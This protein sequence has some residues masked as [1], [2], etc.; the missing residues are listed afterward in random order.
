M[1]SRHAGESGAPTTGGKH[2]GLAGPIHFRHLPTDQP[3]SSDDTGARATSRARGGVDQAQVEFLEARRL[4]SAATTMLETPV[5]LYRIDAAMNGEPLAGALA[6][7]GDVALIEKSRS[8]FTGNGWDTS[9]VTIDMYDT[10][11]DSVSAYAVPGNVFRQTAA[12]VGG[13]ALFAGGEPSLGSFAPTSG[14]E[15]YDAASGQWSTANLSLA[16]A[17][18]AAGSV[19][20]LALFGGGFTGYGDFGS[21]GAPTDVVDIYDSATGSWS[22]TTMPLAAGFQSAVTVGHRVVFAGGTQA[23]SGHPAQAGAPVNVFDATTGQ[24]TSGQMPAQVFDGLKVAAAGHYALFAGTS[25]SDGTF[26]TT[27]DVYDAD[28]GTWSAVE[29]S[30]NR[31]DFTA[32]SVGDLAFFAGGTYRTRHFQEYPSRVVD[33]FD[34]TTGRWSTLTLPGAGGPMVATVVGGRPVFIGRDGLAQTYDPATGQWSTQRL[35]GGLA[36]MAP[37]PVGDGAVI[38]GYTYR[39]SDGTYQ[40]AIEALSPST[41]AGPGSPQP[42]A[43]ASLGA[44]PTSLSWSAVGGARGYDVYLDGRPVARGLANTTYTPAAAISAGPHTWQ[45]VARLGP[46]SAVASETFA[47]TSPAPRVRLTVTGTTLP[48]NQSLGTWSTGTATVV[49]RNAGTAPLPAG[50]HVRAYGTYDDQVN[51]D[52]TPVGDATLHAP[53]P[54]GAS[55]T[56]TVPLSFAGYAPFLIGH[57]YSESLIFTVE[58]G[59]RRRGGGHLPAALATAGGPAVT[60]DSTV[61]PPTTGDGGAATAGGYVRG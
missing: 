15:I 5:S 19:D 14:V 48:A 58:Q 9:P 57:T 37:V 20:G 61:Q 35:S 33:V 18:M 24:W 25:E 41:V 55:R 44:G 4:L 45:V 53:L 23:D 31:G 10:A 1:Y 8:Y 43:G 60:I 49:V 34:A 16:R 54:P 46:R 39:R 12:S 17:D 42:A 6:T 59:T 56:V 52:S 7:A 22:A 26:N 3:M 28:T 40:V 51:P 13:Q 30:Q 47:F 2:V 21:H 36:P 29:L 50:A 11:H 27:A 32:V 38:E